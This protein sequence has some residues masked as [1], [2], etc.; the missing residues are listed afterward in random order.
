MAATHATRGVD[1][2]TERTLLR[3]VGA[4]LL[5]GLFLEIIAE[6][7]HPSKA[8]A[9]NHTAAF[10]EYAKSDGFT[11]THVF[12][13]FAILVGIA[14]LLVLY[15]A[16]AL[17]A[18][19]PVLTRLAAAASIATAAAFA[20]LQAIDGVALKQA[21]DAWAKASGAEKS[22]RFA[23]AETVRWLEWGAN[24]YFRLLLGVS[25]LLFGAAIVRSLLL[26]RWLGG[27]AALAGM[28]FVA[29]GVI[30]G[31]DGFSHGG[32]G[33]SLAAIV[34][35]LVFSAGILVVGWR[36]RD[37]PAAADSPAPA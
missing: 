26:P 31:E 9:N 23:D 2:M 7:F 29:L 34:F 27:S 8:D 14:G 6:V 11:A 3:V 28:F 36:R 19:A 25:L 32:S 33:V 1:A 16:L 5:G 20:V 35:Y 15:R 12:Q 18:E 37:P 30:V 21:V 22:V 17:R 13:F 10:A 4:L 24:S